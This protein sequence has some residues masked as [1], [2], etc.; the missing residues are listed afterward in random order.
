MSAAAVTVKF[1]LPDVFT[2]VT[3]S[4][5]VA[6]IAFVPV[7]TPVARPLFAL[8]LAFMVATVISA[9]DQTTDDDVVSG[10]DVPSEKLPVAVNCW[11][12]PLAMLGFG[13]VIEMD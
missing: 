1:V 5:N 12:K 3:G 10:S 7:P 6:V 8:P 9:E 11:V 4:V 13:G 2:N